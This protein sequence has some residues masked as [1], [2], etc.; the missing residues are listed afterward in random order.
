MATARRLHWMNVVFPGEI[1][2]PGNTDGIIAPSGTTAERPSPPVGGTIR[3]NSTTNV[4]ESYIN[5]S[6]ESLLTATGVITTFIG[7][8]DTFG[9]YS[10]LANE[11][12]VVNA[13][14]TGIVTV[15]ADTLYLPRVGGI[16]DTNADITVTGG[17]EFLGLPSFPSTANAATSK[18]YVDG[19]VGP[20]QSWSADLSN[21]GAGLGTRILA[22]T[23]P[24]ST[25]KPIT[26][27]ITIEKISVT[28]SLDATIEVNGQF[29]VRHSEV[30]PA[31][32]GKR[33][34]SV[35]VPA[36]ES[37][38]VNIVGSPTNADIFTWYELSDGTLP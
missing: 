15:D 29:I 33:N 12:L 27:N 38:R 25:S 6:W 4:L 14:A 5:G 21:T 18:F 26:V 36:G 2:F 23:Y 9:N 8:S 19:Q 34:L 31:A 16:M 10:G 3:Y 20:P 11:F 24:N 28:G 35:V 7:L 1:D 37:Y 30:A 17:G 13:G 22:T 32:T